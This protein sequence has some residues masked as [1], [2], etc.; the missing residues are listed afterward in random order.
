MLA[1]GIGDRRR[2]GVELAR[3]WLLNDRGRIVMDE[4]RAVLS[5]IRQHEQVLLR[6]RDRAAR[7]SAFATTGLILLGSIAGIIAVAIASRM[8]RRDLRR[9]AEVESDLREARD[10]LEERVRERTAEL[11]AVIETSPIPIAAIDPKGNVTLWNRAA[12]EVFGYTRDEMLGKPY[13]PVDAEDRKNYENV[14]KRITAGEPIAA[15]ETRARRKDASM[16]DVAIYSAPLRPPWPPPRAACAGWGPDRAEPPP[17]PPAP[18]AEEGGRRQARGRHRARLQQPPHRD[19]RLHRAR[20]AASAPADIGARARARSAGRR[21]AAA[22]TRQLLAFSRSRC[23]APGARPERRGRQPGDDAR[24]LI[25]EDVD[26]VSLAQG[27]GRVKADPGQLE[28]VL[29]NLASTRAT[30][31]RA[32]G[33]LTIETANVDL[34]EPNPRATRTARRATT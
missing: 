15:L 18:A 9:R 13:A 4:T 28:Q 20:A 17:G 2:G 30:R 31:C 1:D 5:E 34:A 11:E 22:L 24:R 8:V 25:G 26:V 3:Q 7:Q 32:G 16:L 14:M 12:E 6:R 21:R 23:S 10:R 29:M 19:P 33:T 27:V